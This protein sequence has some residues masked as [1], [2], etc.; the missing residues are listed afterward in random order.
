MV[1]EMLRVLEPYGHLHVTFPLRATSCRASWDAIKKLLIGPSTFGFTLWWAKT[2]MDDPE[3]EW[4][5]HTLE[6]AHDGTTGTTFANRTFYD[7]LG[8]E[9]FLAR[10]KS[11]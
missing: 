1:D 3:I 9:A 11:G 2:Q 10:R 7:I 6:E 8:F 4:L 5:Y